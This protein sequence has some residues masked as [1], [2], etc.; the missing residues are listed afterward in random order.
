MR[1]SAEEKIPDSDSAEAEGQ[2]RAAGGE[3]TRTLQVS[4]T[5]LSSAACN[6]RCTSFR[7]CIRG[8]GV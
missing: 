6:H 5:P 4:T 3:D 7:P 2:L 1:L 8:T